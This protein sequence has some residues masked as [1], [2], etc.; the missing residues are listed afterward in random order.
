MQTFEQFCAEPGEDFTRRA[1][2]NNVKIFQLQKD[3]LEQRKT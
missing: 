2:I 3:N 1:M